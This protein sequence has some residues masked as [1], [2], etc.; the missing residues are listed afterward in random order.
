MN[1]ALHPQPPHPKK[2]LRENICYDLLI[3]LFSKDI[4][5]TSKHIIIIIIMFL[6]G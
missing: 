5:Q 3:F 1:Q 6:K 4:F 2:H